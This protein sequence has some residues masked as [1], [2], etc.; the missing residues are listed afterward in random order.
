MLHPQHIFLGYMPDGALLYEGFNSGLRTGQSSEFALSIVLL[1][2]L[3]L[4]VIC[5]A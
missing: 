5:D 2:S 4:S 1:L 3:S